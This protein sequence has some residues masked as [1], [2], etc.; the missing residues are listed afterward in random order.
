MTFDL[1]QQTMGKR[2]GN[3]KYIGTLEVFPRLLDWA[4]VGSIVFSIDSNAPRGIIA[5]GLNNRFDP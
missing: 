4:S 3:T 5:E 2:M 1:N